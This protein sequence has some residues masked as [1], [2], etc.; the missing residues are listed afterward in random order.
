MLN[1][2]SQIPLLK[3]VVVASGNKVAIGDNLKEALDNNITCKIVDSKNEIQLINKK[4]VISILSIITL[5]CIFYL[6]MFFRDIRL[7]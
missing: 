7:R 4:I 5:V 1:D 2:E 6:S 3:K